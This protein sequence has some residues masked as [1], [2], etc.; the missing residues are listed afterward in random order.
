ML[1]FLVGLRSVVS[2]Y[3]KPTKSNFNLIHSV[4][5]YKSLIF[6]VC[7]A[8]CLKALDTFCNCQ[9]PVV[10]RGIS[11]QMNNITNLWKFELNR[12]SKLRDNN[13]RKNTLVIR[14]CVLSN[15][16][17]WDLKIKFLGLEIKFKNHV[18]S[19]GAVSRNV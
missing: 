7:A 3:T 15:A 12:S 14:S 16:W 11:Q 1:Y 8:L 6:S 5:S 2:H 4:Q 18:T 9:R 19:E 17:F 10:P 13:G